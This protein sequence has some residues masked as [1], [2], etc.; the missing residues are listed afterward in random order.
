MSVTRVPIRR[1]EL[2]R[3]ART[4]RLPCFASVFRQIFMIDSPSAHDAIMI[5]CVRLPHPVPWQHSRSRLEA[6]AGRHLFD[7]TGAGGENGVSW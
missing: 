2:L 3:M 1:V 7:V 5:D 4:R 6:D